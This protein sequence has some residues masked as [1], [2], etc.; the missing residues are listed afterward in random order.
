MSQ[1]K[2]NSDQKAFLGVLFVKCHVYGRLYKD[3]QNNAYVGSCPR[4][5]TSIS[6]KI[7]ASGTDARFF[8]V[9]CGS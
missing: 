2:I 8:E 6:V 3:K 1:Q 4:C 9:Y 5:G 7:G